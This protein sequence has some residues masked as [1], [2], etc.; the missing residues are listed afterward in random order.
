[1]L[2]FPLF[3]V[4][5]QIYPIQRRP[6]RPPNSEFL[7]QQQKRRNL[8]LTLE[9][10]HVPATVVSERR[11]K[12]AHVCSYRQY[13]LPYFLYDFDIF[14]S[15]GLKRHVQKVVPSTPQFGL[16]AN[17]NIGPKVENPLTPPKMPPGVVPN[18][19]LEFSKIKKSLLSNLRFRKFECSFIDKAESMK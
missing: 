4:H 7:D 5:F 16:V 6:T 11:P 18:W 12:T 8:I 1:M 3:Y 2:L 15:S 19:V 9:K 10:A 13:I 17:E 14:T